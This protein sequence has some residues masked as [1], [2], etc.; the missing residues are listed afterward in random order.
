MA[1]VRL[2]FEGGLVEGSRELFQQRLIEGLKAAA[3]D[4]APGIAPPSAAAPAAEYQVTGKVAINN[5]SYEIALE[6]IN[7]RTGRVIGSNRERCEI[8]G[9]E[10]A[11]EKMG[12]AASALRARLEALAK[13]P[14]RFTI[15]TRPPGATAT[16]DGSPLGRTPIDR[17]IPGGPHKLTLGADGY[18]SLERTFT[19]VSGVDE[20]LDLELLPI[21]SKFPFRTAGWIAVG[22]GVALMA[23]GIWAVVIDGDEIACDPSQRDV[24][25]NCPKVRDSRLLGAAL[26]GAGAVSLTLGGVWLYFGAINA[27]AGARSAAAR[28][29]G[30]LF[31]RATF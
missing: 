27:R 14:A 22:A 11:A 28:P 7:G 2:D 18:T 30:G 29:T 15:R 24:L 26:A 1:V 8:C 25:N 4:V 23:A 31:L 12:L 16:L 9:V 10:E 13:T 21:A 19:A 20:S 6:L 17:E 3:F 5:R